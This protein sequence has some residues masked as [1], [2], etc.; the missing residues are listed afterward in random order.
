MEIYCKIM[1]IKNALGKTSNNPYHRV[2]TDKGSFNCHEPSVIEELNPFVGGMCTLAI[3][4]TPKADGN[5]TWK[6]VIG[7][8]KDTDEAKSKLI[9]NHPNNQNTPSV[10]VEDV[11]SYQPRVDD[12]TICILVSYAKDMY[13]SAGNRDLEGDVHLTPEEC[14]GIVSKMYKDMAESVNAV[15]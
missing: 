5:G 10:P 8:N 4:E 9:I 11:E 12:K 6:N 2:I 15:D 3:R 1:E 7:I 14:I 13:T